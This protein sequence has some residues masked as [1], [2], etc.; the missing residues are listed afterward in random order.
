MREFQLGF[1]AASPTS[2]AKYNLAD[3]PISANLVLRPS[4]D[5]IRNTSGAKEAIL[6]NKNCMEHIWLL[7]FKFKLGFIII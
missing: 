4:H 1:V 6:F 7:K 3:A 5:N 2:K